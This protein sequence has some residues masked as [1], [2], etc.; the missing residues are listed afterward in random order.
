MTV[1]KLDSYLLEG[2]YDFVYCGANNDFFSQTNGNFAI[3]KHLPID[4]TEYI[5]FPTE[6]TTEE[7]TEGTTEDTTTE[8][9]KGTPTNGETSTEG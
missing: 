5:T 2:D 8:I 4:Y 9:C 3:N 1:T 7:N 6:E